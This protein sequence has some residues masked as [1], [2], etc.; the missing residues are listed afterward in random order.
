[1]SILGR[2]YME[3]GRYQ[4]ARCHLEKAVTKYGINAPESAELLKLLDEIKTDR[5]KKKEKKASQSTSQE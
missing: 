5:E 1:M 3:T 2:Y 4:P